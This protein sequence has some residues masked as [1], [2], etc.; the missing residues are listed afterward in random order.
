MQRITSNFRTAASA[1]DQAIVAHVLSA[2]EL[3][4]VGGGY[5]DPIKGILILETIEDWMILKEI[6]EGVPKI[7]VGD[8]I[9]G[10]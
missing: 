9:K 6:I 3:N 4:Q 1:P 7:N 5:Y 2:A 8:L 10:R